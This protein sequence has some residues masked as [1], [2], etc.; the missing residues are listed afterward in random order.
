MGKAIAQPF[1]AS[2]HVVI[3][4]DRDA[5]ALAA[6][7]ELGA[8]HIGVAGDVCDE[9]LLARVCQQA[10]ASGD[11]LR[12]FV[13]NAGII[14]PGPST[15]QSVDQWNDLLG[16]NLT[17]VFLGDNI[18][19]VFDADRQP[20]DYCNAEVVALLPRASVAGHCGGMRNQRLTPPRL[21]AM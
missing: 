1:A 20:E 21:G 13:A 9:D 14:G 5:V 12:C 6:T 16:V 19:H 18:L 17:G 7:F 15:E 10:V 3:G 2:G 4:V 8:P 11:G